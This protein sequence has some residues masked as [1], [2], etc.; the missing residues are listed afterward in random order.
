VAILAFTIALERWMRADNE[1][2]FLVH[3]AA[4]L[5]DL[6]ARAAEL[7]SRSRLSA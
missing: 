3:A 7:D 4:A 5:S 6:Q 1:E 2:P